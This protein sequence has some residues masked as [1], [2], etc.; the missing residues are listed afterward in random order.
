MISYYTTQTDAYNCGYFCYWKCTTSFYLK[1]IIQIILA[2]TIKGLWELAS[3]PEAVVSFQTNI[4]QE[5][6]KNFGPLLVHH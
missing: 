6:I 5:T 3:R 1:C 2:K 4:W